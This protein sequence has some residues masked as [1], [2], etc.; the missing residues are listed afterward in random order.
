MGR[1]RVFQPNVAAISGAPPQTLQGSSSDGVS[2]GD[3]PSTRW[4]AG[5]SVSDGVAVALTAAA[6]GTQIDTALTRFDG[7]SGAY[8]V[9]NGVLFAE[10]DVT[11]AMVS[12]RQIR[13][14]IGGVEKQVYTEALDGRWPDGSVKSVLIQFSHTWS[15]TAT[16]Q[17]VLGSTRGTSDISKQTINEAP[18]A[19]HYPSSSTYLCSAYPFQ[20]WDNVIPQSQWP[21]GTYWDT[22]VANMEGASNYGFEFI[23]NRLQYIEGISGHIL[24][25]YGGANY[26]ILRGSYQWFCANPAKPELVYR[27]L[28]ITDRM[29]TEYCE[30]N[31]WG[32]PE[33]RYCLVCDTVMHY[34]LTGDTTSETAPK[35]ILTART[36]TGWVA[37]NMETT[38]YIYNHGRPHYNFLMAMVLADH[39]GLTVNS[40]DPSAGSTW[41]QKAASWVSAA[42]TQQTASAALTEDLP[43]YILD[44]I[45]GANNWKDVSS[46]WNSGGGY[47]TYCGEQLWQAAMRHLALQAYYHWISSTSPSG[48]AAHIKAHWD[49][50][51]TAG[52]D[53]S[54]KGWPVNGGYRAQGSWVA[55]TADVNSYNLGELAFLYRIYGTAAYLT[56]GDAA[57]DGLGTQSYWE[58]TVTI[59]AGKQTIEK[60]WQTTNYIAARQ[61]S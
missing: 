46:Y 30:L 32:L 27:G 47:C 5:A 18:D 1:V 23:W 48:I 15:G 54:N 41:A 56:A 21:T 52:W 31:N 10:G 19:F 4:D 61:G 50:Y 24:D 8:T 44:G 9:T 36:G 37:S 13:V 49:Y 43:N 14:Y 20:P 6:G 26:D 40:F 59:N 34:W 7:G 39:L 17:I 60:L 51:G 53:A 35:D 2:L 16:G 55:G 42:M 38:D 25:L 11:D 58:N 28:Y 33:E 12:N 3:S 45:A 22:F 29:L 57:M